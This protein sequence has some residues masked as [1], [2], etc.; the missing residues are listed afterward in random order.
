M[1]EYY[2]FFHK[3]KYI[4]KQL[5]REIQLFLYTCTLIFYMPKEDFCKFCWVSAVFA[6]SLQKRKT[7][8]LNIKT[9]GYGVAD[10]FLYYH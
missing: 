7:E 4:L 6:V 9:Y 3:L 1:I 2:Y 8:R 10:Q 5:G